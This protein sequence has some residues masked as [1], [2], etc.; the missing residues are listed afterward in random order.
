VVVQT[1]ENSSSCWG[2][3]SQKK[4]FAWG[5]CIAQTSQNLFASRAGEKDYQLFGDFMVLPRGG[6]W[7]RVFRARNYSPHTRE[8]GVSTIGTN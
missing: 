1:N 8:G 5:V 7:G 6:V 4:H 3:S 2:Q